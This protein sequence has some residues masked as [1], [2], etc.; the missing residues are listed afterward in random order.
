MSTR[1][2]RLSV[3]T[4]F[5][6]ALTSAPVTSLAYPFT[7]PLDTAA[8]QTVTAPA[9]PVRSLLDLVAQED[10][11]LWSALQSVYADSYVP[12]GCDPTC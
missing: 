6:L 4:A 5:A 1:V 8:Q 12:T 10:S 7:T 9:D 11:S 3:V 2:R